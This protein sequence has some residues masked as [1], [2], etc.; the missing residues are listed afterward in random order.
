MAIQLLAHG[1][2]KSDSPYTELKVK[3]PRGCLW[4]PL[5]MSVVESQPKL[6]NSKHVDIRLCDLVL[7]VGLAFELAIRLS[8]YARKLC[9]LVDKA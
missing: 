6:D 2:I 5:S 3:L 9:V 4:S 7:V 1:G 8:H